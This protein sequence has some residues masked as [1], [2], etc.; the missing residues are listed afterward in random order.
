MDRQKHPCPTSAA[1]GNL[2][3]DSNKLP[4]IQYQ[5]GGNKKGCIDVAFR[6]DYS[7]NAKAF[8][9]KLKKYPE[10]TPTIPVIIN[11][12]GTVFED[13]MKLL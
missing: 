13:S 7:E 8:R 6:E 10:F 9:G 5:S 12:D 2:I 1:H 4:D 11:Y 3:A